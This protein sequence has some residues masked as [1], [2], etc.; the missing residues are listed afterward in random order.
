MKLSKLYYPITSTPFKKNVSYTEFEPCTAL[1][2][3]IRCFWGTTELIEE[4]SE[5]TLVIP[6]TC[7]DIIFTANYTNNLLK[8]NFCGINDRTFTAKSESG[9]TVFS[10]GIR[11][12]AWGTAMFSEN[13][14]NNT[15]NTFLNADEHFSRLKKAI[16]PFMFYIS[17]IQKLI[18]ITE[19]ALLSILN[20][21]HKNN[22]VI[23]AIGK[24]LENKGSQRIG[25]LSREIHI[26]ERQLER[27][28]Q[29]YIGCS[30]K[31]LS[32]MIRY[33]S[34]WNE[35]MF[36]KNF[37]ILN[38][39]LKYGYTDQSHLIHDFK[40]YHSLNIKEAKE[41]A[42]RNVGNLQDFSLRI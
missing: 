24:I 2:P 16:E 40:K 31:S 28:F 4:N 38:A 32:A 3:Y 8:S 23:E 5:N 26:S 1:K 13:S 36:N 22:I 41:H 21:K 19:Q 11:F 14:L 30:V 25:E 42:L 7:M 37:D 27:I 39:V 34:L 9:S 33:Q 17:D 29:E 15:R 12:Y 35:I 6:D 18:P 20:E 10:F